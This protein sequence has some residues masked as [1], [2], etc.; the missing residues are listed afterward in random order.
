MAYDDGSGTPE[1]VPLSQRVSV[2]QRV[3]R[4][5]SGCGTGIL[6]GKAYERTVGLID[7]VLTTS[8]RHAWDCYLYD[9]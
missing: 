9:Y 6:P 1:W 2:A 8:R 7:G 4:C 3:Y 5:D